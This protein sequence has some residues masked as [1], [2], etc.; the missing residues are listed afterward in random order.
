MKWGSGGPA[1]LHGPLGTH[2]EDRHVK[3]GY[4]THHMGK[5]TGSNVEVPVLLKRARAGFGQ[6]SKEREVENPLD[7]LNIKVS[8]GVQEFVFKNPC[9]MSMAFVNNAGLGVQVT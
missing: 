9:S 6:L 7:P 2:N 4:T 5:C 8:V 1:Q 3:A